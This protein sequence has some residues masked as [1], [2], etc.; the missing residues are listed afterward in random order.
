MP[1]AAVKLISGSLI[2]FVGIFH[3]SSGPVTG[4]A[5]NI[6]PIERRFSPWPITDHFARGH[7]TAA[8]RSRAA[9]RRG[10]FN[11]VSSQ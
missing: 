7:W 1:R 8:G 9:L 6:R 3:G 5:N 4:S 11:S 10:K 2:M